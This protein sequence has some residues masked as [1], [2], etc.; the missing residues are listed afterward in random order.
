M[1]TAERREREKAERKMLIQKCALEVFAKFGY[2]G[3]T[4]DKI[5]DKAELS[6]GAIYLYF[7]DKDELFSSLIQNGIE[8]FRDSVHH[9]VEDI[10]DPLLR[11]R[12]MIAVMLEYFGVRKN[13]IRVFISTAGRLSRKAQSDFHKILFNARDE[14]VEQFKW[15]LRPA[16]ESGLFQDG[17]TLEIGAVFFQSTVMGA[18]TWFLTHEQDEIDEKRTGDILYQLY[19]NG[20]FKTAE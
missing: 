15:V 1:G 11:I 3:A 2:E 12:K 16:F 10:D 19:I 13:L 8:E 6:K 18:V 7:K 4:V 5:A 17:I 9:A 20:V 14:A